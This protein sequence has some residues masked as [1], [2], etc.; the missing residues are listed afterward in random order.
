MIKRKAILTT[1]TLVSHGSEKSRIRPESLP[2]GARDNYMPFRRIPVVL[3]NGDAKTIVNIPA[4]SG[5]SIRH[6]LREELADFTLFTLGLDKKNLDKNTLDLFMNGG[7]MDKKDTD[8][9]DKENKEGLTPNYPILVRDRE[10]LRSVLPIFSLFGCSYGNRMIGGLVKVGW[11]I[12]AL[13]QTEHI[14]GVPSSISYNEDITSFQLLTRHDPNRDEEGTSKQAI[15]YTEVL[16]AGIPL[17]HEISIDSNSTPLERS[18]LQLAL[19]LFKQKPFIGGKSATGHG[20]VST[21][22]WYEPFEES[23]QIYIDYLKENKDVIT[24]YIRLWHQP[25]EVVK[26]KN[27]KESIEFPIAHQLDQIVNARHKALQEQQSKFY[28]TIGS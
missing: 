8:R 28:Q 26:V 4:I 3:Q 15:S 13:K 24:E 18:A 2:S 21:D 25:K 11:A 7:G 12:P 5:N 27:K 20:E 16:S 17:A 10:T 6:L 14:T 19:D 9:N 1:K 23:S 22:Q